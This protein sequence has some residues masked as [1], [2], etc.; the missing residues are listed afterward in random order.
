MERPMPTASAMFHHANRLR[1]A[2]HMLLSPLCRESGLPPM[3]LDILLYVANNPQNN[4]ATQ[5][6]ES[7][8]F[9]SAIVSVHIERLVRAGLLCRRTDPSDRRKN[10]LCCTEAAAPLIEQG[11]ML[12]QTFADDL[13]AGLD[14]A[15]LEAMHACFV[16]ID[17]NINAILA[18]SEEKGEKYHA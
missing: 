13:L 10:C 7:R 12:Q 18:Q 5:I 3:A 14:R 4:T 8:G 6:C 17:Q 16:K 15:Q 1:K 9:K 11:R 2:Y